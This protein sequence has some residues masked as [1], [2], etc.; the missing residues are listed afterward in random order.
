MAV[1]AS[2]KL[3]S[4]GV[5]VLASVELAPVAVL[6]FAALVATLLELAFF[7]RFA[8]IEGV[9]AEL[10]PACGFSFT[11]RT[12]SRGGFPT[13][14]RSSGGFPRTRS[15]FS[16]ASLCRTRCSYGFTPAPL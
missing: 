16:F 11:C 9:L 12:R 10:T 3:A 4:V 6:E 15:S 14:T 13:R 2:V 1:L 8:L 5:L 7:E